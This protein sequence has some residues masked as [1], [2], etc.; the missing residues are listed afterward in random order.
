M[1]SIT[2]CIRKYFTFAAINKITECYKNSLAYAEAKGKTE[3]KAESLAESEAER[4]K[5]QQEIEEL[6]RLLND[7]ASDPY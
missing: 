7:T 2:V 3:G 5:L 6:K 4:L 1:F